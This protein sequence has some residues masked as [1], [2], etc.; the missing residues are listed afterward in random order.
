MAICS[1]PLG[2]VLGLSERTDMDLALCAALGVSRA[3]EAWGYLQGD[4]YSVAWSK[5]GDVASSLRGDLGEWM[6]LG[7]LQGP[8][9]LRVVQG[10]HTGWAQSSCALLD[11]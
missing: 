9:G 3:Q 4:S 8:Q 5:W 2:L 11:F 6:G 7:C 1:E 10:S